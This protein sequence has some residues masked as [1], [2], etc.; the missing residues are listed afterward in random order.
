MECERSKRENNMYDEAIAIRKILEREL[1]FDG[2]AGE[3][4]RCQ[5]VMRTADVMCSGVLH[6]FD[7]RYE[8]QVEIVL[9]GNE[10]AV[11]RET[12]DRLESEYG[13]RMGLKTLNWTDEEIVQIGW[14]CIDKQASP[15]VPPKPELTLEQQWVALAEG[16]YG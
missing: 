11:G 9:S 7:T 15:I 16:G 8:I 5:P 3:Y 10:H 14:A 12:L 4:I 13:L 1:G 2:S 6:T